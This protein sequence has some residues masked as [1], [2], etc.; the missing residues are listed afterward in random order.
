MKLATDKL[1]VEKEGAIGWLTFNNPARLNAMSQEMWEGTADVMAD[2][3][4]DPA[5]RVVVM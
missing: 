2:F 1:I 3:A 5:I 4:A